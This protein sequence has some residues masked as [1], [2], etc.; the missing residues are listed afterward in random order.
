MRR[1]RRKRT[2]RRCWR[3]QG[4]D[5]SK[6]GSVLPA[7]VHPDAVVSIRVTVSVIRVPVRRNPDRAAVRWTDPRA[8]NRSVSVSGP[9]RV[10]RNPHVSVRRVRRGRRRRSI[11]GCRRRCVDGCRRRCVDGRRRRCVDRSR[12]ADPDVHRE[13]TVTGGVRIDRQQNNCPDSK[14]CDSPHHNRPPRWRLKE[15]S[16]CQAEI[17]ENRPD[18]AEITE[19]RPDERTQKRAPKRPQNGDRCRERNRHARGKNTPFRSVPKVAKSLEDVSSGS[20]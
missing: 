10:R 20:D 6:R 12:Y 11:N 13:V 16:S 14:K 19:L 4:A 5:E 3:I 9:H 1:R 18:F 15:R 8:G 7:A 17:E 2:W